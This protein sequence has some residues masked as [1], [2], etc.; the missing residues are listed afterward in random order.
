VYGEEGERGV[1]VE[2]EVE[3][4]VG[5]EGAVTRVLHVAGDLAHGPAHLREGQE[6]ATRV[7]NFVLLIKN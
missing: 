3:R 6:H 1:P 5:G 7:T 2:G 4:L